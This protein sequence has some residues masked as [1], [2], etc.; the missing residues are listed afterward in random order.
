MSEA[1]YSYEV[2]RKAD[3]GLFLI[4]DTDYSEPAKQV[5]DGYVEQHPDARIALW[6][7][8][9]LAARLERH[10]HLLARYGL[11]LPRSDPVAAFAPLKRLGPV[12]T[13]LLS[14]QSALA[15]NLTSALGAAGFDVTFLPFWNYLDA[16]RLNLARRTQAVIYALK[17]GI[18][19]LNGDDD[20]I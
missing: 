20:L 7:Q 3:E 15:H 17:H 14:D 10:P 13:L 12:R 4:V 11:S 8:R 9:Q 2:N 18:V 19:E 16:G 5:I 6:N 1:I